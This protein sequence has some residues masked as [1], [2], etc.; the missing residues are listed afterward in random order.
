MSILQLEDLNS[1]CVM[2]ACC[3]MLQP[4]GGLAEATP[5]SLQEKEQASTHRAGGLLLELDLICSPELCLVCCSLNLD[6]L[7]S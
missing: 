6:R 3:R 1:L 2:Q 4:Q 7:D 5:D